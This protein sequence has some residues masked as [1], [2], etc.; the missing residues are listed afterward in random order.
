MSLHES[1]YSLYIEHLL[2]SVLTKI[3]DNKHS[4]SEMLVI[5]TFNMVSYP[6]RLETSSALLVEPLFLEIRVL[7]DFI[8]RLLDSY[9]E[10]GSNS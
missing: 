8:V 5:L 10:Y 4:F 9:G 7:L 3:I 6:R 2:I 1:W